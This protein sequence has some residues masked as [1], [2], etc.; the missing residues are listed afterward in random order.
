MGHVIAALDEL[1]RARRAAHRG[2]PRGGRGVR[3][4]AARR[5]GRHRLALRA[6]RTGTST[7]TATTPTSGRGCGARI[8]AGPRRSSPGRLRAEHE[9]NNRAVPDSGSVRRRQAGVLVVGATERE[10]HPW[11]RAAGHTT[12]VAPG[13]DA[14][15]AALGEE[16]ADLVIVDRDPG[17]L[18]TPDLCRALHADPRL[19]G[20]WMLADHGQGQH[21]R[22]PRSPPAPTTTCTGRSPAASC[23]RAPVPACARRA[24]L[25]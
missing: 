19:D 10:V 21:G 8:A 16:P 17:G 1:A 12:R 13:V 11:L 24:A 25:R 7:R 3:P 2:P 4:R 5:A 22:T 15:L 6:A 20:A 14:A 18:D 23:W 9:L